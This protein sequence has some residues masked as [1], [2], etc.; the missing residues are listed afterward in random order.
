MSGLLAA[1]DGL[2]KAEKVGKNGNSVGL[3]KKVFYR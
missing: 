2:E 3:S 1:R